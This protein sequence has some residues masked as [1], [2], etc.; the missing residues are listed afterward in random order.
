MCYARSM[1]EAK[2]LSGAFHEIRSPRYKPMTN[3]TTFIG[4]DFAWQ[5]ERNATAIAVARGENASATLIDVV[6]GLAGLN[7]IAAFV[8]RSATEH[9]VIAID[10]PLIIRN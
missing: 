3:R 10:A 6:S 8:G 4:I 9:T 7:E 5:S 2:K 1:T